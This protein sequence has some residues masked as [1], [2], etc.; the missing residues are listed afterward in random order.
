MRKYNFKNDYKEYG[1]DNKDWNSFI[2]ENFVNPAELEN[3]EIKKL[4]S[5]LELVYKTNRDLKKKVGELEKENEKI[6]FNPRNKKFSLKSIQENLENN[7]DFLSEEGLKSLLTAEY[8]Y[9][10]ENE[11]IDFSSS[12]LQYIKTFEIE[13]K[14]RVDI[15]DLT[16]GNLIERI[17][18]VGVFKNFINEIQKNRVVE[19]RNRGAHSTIISKIECGRV[20][21]LFLEEGWL[22]RVIEYF[23]REKENNFDSSE[24]SFVEFKIIKELD[25]EIFNGKYYT[26][27]STLEGEYIL[28]N[29]IC[30]SGK[31]SGNG[32][33]I[34]LKG[35][36]YI[37]ID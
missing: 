24:T 6:K 18:Q 25:R 12:Y 30:N 11:G 7:Y 19:N 26:C 34:D 16:F 36:E 29:K 32:R 9:L 14:K 27:F 33:K 21:K 35:I 3:E 23:E 22:E 31:I 17:N 13:L 20:R 37:L 2:Y 5:E 10:N 4:R 8:I 15:K 28:T 1:F